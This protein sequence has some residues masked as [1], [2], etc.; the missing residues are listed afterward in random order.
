[1]LGAILA[2][3]FRDFA[4]IIEGF[5]RIFRDF[6]LDFK[7]FAHIFRDF[8]Q[9]FNKSKFW[10]CACNPCT[11]PP[12]PMIIG[13]LMFYKDGLE[14]NTLQLCTSPENSECFFIIFV[15]ILRST[16]LLRRNKHNCYGRRVFW[17]L[18]QARGVTR[19]Q[20]GVTTRARNHYGGS[21][22]LRGTPKRSKNVTSSSIQYICFRK[23]SIGTWRRQ[24]C[25]LPWVPSNL[26][27]PLL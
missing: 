2:Q 13:H 9:I 21:E 23:T 5:V 27:T 15:I 18:L 10:G 25:F 4:Y 3:I 7:E 6:A 24:T 19:G 1:M 8:A 11:P 22:W 17:G 26:V 20:R 12:T 16:L 14:T